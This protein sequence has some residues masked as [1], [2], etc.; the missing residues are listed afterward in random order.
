MQ[1]PQQG[2]RCARKEEAP[3]CGVTGHT[4][5]ET[6]APSAVV[7]L[8][9]AASPLALGG[10]Q[11]PWERATYLEIFCIPFGGGDSCPGTP[12][13]EHSDPK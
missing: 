11:L 13:E 5:S 2:P 4:C 12:R 8:G 9:L 6:E 1:L 7:G 10:S 3:S